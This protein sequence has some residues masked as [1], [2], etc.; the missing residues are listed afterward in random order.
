MN[1]E[2]ELLHDEKMRLEVKIERILHENADAILSHFKSG[3]LP[4]QLERK[5]KIPKN[6]IIKFLI[7]KLGIVDFRK[8][9]EFNIR[10]SK[11]IQNNI[12]E[13]DES[14]KKRPLD[15]NKIKQDKIKIIERFSDIIIQMYK[16]GETIRYIADVLGLDFFA[17]NEFIYQYRKSRDV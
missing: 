2:Y 12:I 6:K 10:K 7:E 4:V 13:N 8:Q 17:V 14:K 11:A 16:R 1:S 9:M 5:Y 15:Q 3:E